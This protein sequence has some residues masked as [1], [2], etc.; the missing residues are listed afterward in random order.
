ME[1]GDF[2]K[3]I[4]CA[5]IGHLLSGLLAL[6]VTLTVLDNFVILMRDDNIIII[7]RPD[8]AAI[9]LQEV[10]KLLDLLIVSMWF[11]S[12][13]IYFTY[14]NNNMMIAATICNLFAFFQ[15]YD[16]TKQESK[17]KIRL[18]AIVFGVLCGMMAG[19]YMTLAFWCLQSKS[20]TNMTGD[21]YQLIELYNMGIANWIFAVLIVPMSCLTIC[22]KYFRN[23]IVIYGLTFGCTVTIVN[24]L[25]MLFSGEGGS[26]SQFGFACFLSACINIGPICHSQH[27]LSPLA[28]Y[29]HSQQ[30][31]GLDYVKDARDFLRSLVVTLFGR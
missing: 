5:N 24:I 3:Y 18:K 22:F 29:T 6:F 2:V 12:T 4:Y 27:V 10:F 14:L 8:A 21:E 26:S 16:C 19:K 1:H 23:R 30:V 7:F 17:W 11:G 9:H 13:I 20:T 25:M 15:F 28:K 31:L